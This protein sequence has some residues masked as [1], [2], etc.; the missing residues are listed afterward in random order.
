[1]DS[2]YHFL[3]V[4]LFMLAARV[5][6]KHHSFAPFFFGIV[7]LLPDLDH[8]FGFKTRATFHNFF[9]TLLIPLLFLLLAMRLE[10]K[11]VFYKQLTLLLLVSL[12][13]HPLLD[14]PG[15]AGVEYGYPFSTQ[16]YSLG[17][18][19][20]Y[21]PIQTGEMAPL[22][23]TLSLVTLVAMIF[24][25]PIFFLERI[26]SKQEQKPEPVIKAARQTMAEIGKGLKN[27]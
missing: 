21:V 2:L 13:I 3:F 11:G 22:V 26:F 18:T 27:P 19:G 1:M 24:F 20:L 4:F 25:I 5:H 16:R 8:Y 15:N 17:G 14:L 7:T 9:I 6:I 10:K 12:A 23:G